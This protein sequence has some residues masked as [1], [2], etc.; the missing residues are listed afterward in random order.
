[1]LSSDFYREFV[2]NDDFMG[3]DLLNYLRFNDKDFNDIVS[4]GLRTGFIRKFNDLEWDKVSSIDYNMDNLLSDFL[5]FFKDGYNI[6]ASEC[7][8]KMLYIKYNDVDIV[9]GRLPVLDGIVCSK[10]K[11]HWWLETDEYIIDPSL[12]LVFNPVYRDKMGYI[13]DG[14]IFYEDLIDGKGRYV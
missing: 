3:Y 10:G 4:L 13:E 14:R 2:G 8:V 6:G 11:E 12:L 9:Y 7:V 1:M 5:V